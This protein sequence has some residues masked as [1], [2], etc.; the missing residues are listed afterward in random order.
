M[1]TETVQNQ[2][3]EEKKILS[4]YKNAMDKAFAILKGK[5]F[6]PIKSIPNDGVDSIMDEFFAD[7]VKEKK[8][9]FKDKFG[10]L[11]KEKVE[12]DNFIKQKEAE[13]KKVIL[14]KKKEFT[15]KVNSV[16]NIIDGIDKIKAD[17]LKV[18]ETE[19]VEEIKEVDEEK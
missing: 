9:D 3:K 14:T 16:V 10:A 1:N 12:F 17:Y 2:S 5:K 13:F 8:K 7:E 6:A 18:L 15:A 4:G 11:L 19:V